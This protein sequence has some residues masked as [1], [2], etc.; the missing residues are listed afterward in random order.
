MRIQ[1]SIPADWLVRETLQGRLLFHQAGKQYG[2]TDAYETSW[3]HPIT[4]KLPLQD[5]D[6][7]LESSAGRLPYEALSYAWGPPEPQEIAYVDSAQ[8]PGDYAQ[9]TWPQSLS[10]RKNLG[11]ALR[12]L[13]Y[14]DASRMLW[15]DAICISQENIEER[16]EQV[17]L[18]GSVY[19]WARRAI[20]WLG[21]ES[22]EDNSQLAFSTIRYL[23]EQVEFTENGT[24]RMNAPNCER[25]TWSRTSVPLPY[26]NE[27]WQAITQLVRRE[28]FSRL[29]VWQ[30]VKLS[31]KDSI[32]QCGNDSM[33]VYKFGCA[34]RCAAVKPNVPNGET[35]RLL[36]Q[37]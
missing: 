21:S 25:P 37:I 27:T 29:W 15:I 7:Q 32:I 23:G 8:T 35:G 3:T 28:W 17:R 9:H 20:V 6:A 34:V 10:L 30:E 26:T 1:Q 33:S 19:R 22:Q 31:S 24:W 12:Q 11:Q 5:Q 18:M 16:N 14:E 2:P 4:G 36:L 13:R